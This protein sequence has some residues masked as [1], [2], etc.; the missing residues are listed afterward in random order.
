MI[1]SYTRLLVGGSAI[2]LCG[3]FGSQTSENAPAKQRINYYG[4]LVDNKG[5]KLMVDNISIDGSIHDIAFCEDPIDKHHD[6]LDN[7]T[8]L[9]LDQIESIQPACKNPTDAVF[10][11]KTRPF[12]RLNVTLK[13]T[14][15]HTYV[16]ETTKKVLCQVST[17]AGVVHKEVS[18]EGIK[19][20][21]ISGITTRSYNQLQPQQAQCT[22]A[23]ED[24]QKLEQQ[25]AQE[26][27]AVKKGFMQETL[28][29]L[30]SLI[31]SWCS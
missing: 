7:K 11:Y 24:I 12:I 18:F 27:D 22:Q 13:G 21:T 17:G 10:Y 8:Y 26:P 31:T 16:I 14:R 19:Q 1:I 9:N 2:L 25:I 6:P 15:T 3:G 5:R 23:Q 30:K 28:D 4:E 20:L 29:N